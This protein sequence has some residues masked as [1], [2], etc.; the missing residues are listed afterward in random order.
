MRYN[1]KVLRDDKLSK[2]AKLYL[3]RLLYEIKLIS[4]GSMVYYMTRCMISALLR[5]V[6]QE[7]RIQGTCKPAIVS[8][9]GKCH[10]YNETLTSHRKDPL[11]GGIIADALLFESAM[12]LLNHGRKYTEE[13]VLDH[14]TFELFRAS[15]SIT[16]SMINKGYSD[17][18]AFDY[19]RDYMPTQ[20][21]LTD[22]IEELL[23]GK[24]EYKL[25]TIDQPEEVTLNG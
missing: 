9:Y 7:Y 17:E 5:E 10:F 12:Y 24:Y 16:F 19:V 25:G 1:P 14:L 23:D 21:V 4:G 8:A 2:D 13:N 18:E 3:C 22:E 15:A 11:I 6:E 20:H